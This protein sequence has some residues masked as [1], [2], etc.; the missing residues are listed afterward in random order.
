MMAIDVDV[1]P[2]ARRELHVVGFV[3]PMLSVYRSRKGV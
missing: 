1:R 3:T 2:L